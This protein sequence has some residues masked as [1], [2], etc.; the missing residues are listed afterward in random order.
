MRN[1][2]NYVYIIQN[3]ITRHEFVI[4]INPASI[5]RTKQATLLYKLNVGQSTYKY[6]R[7]TVYNI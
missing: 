1:H 2:N 5:R 7:M 4:F 3:A 6:I